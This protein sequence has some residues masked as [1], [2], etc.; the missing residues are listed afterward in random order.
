MKTYL[1][2]DSDKE[3]AVE[4]VKSLND[5]KEMDNYVE[6]EKEAIVFYEDKKFFISDKIPFIFESLSIH[7]VYIHRKSELTQ[8]D[9]DKLRQHVIH[10]Y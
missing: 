7:A 2:I 8:E 1:V 10:Y 5:S 4:Y 3:R 6:Y 9:Q